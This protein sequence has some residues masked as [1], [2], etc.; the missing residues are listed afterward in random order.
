MIESIR[1]VDE[2]ANDVDIA[3]SSTICV[4][5]YKV[6]DGLNFRTVR[7]GVNASGPSDC[8][9][10]ESLVQRV[11]AAGEVRER[12]TNLNDVM[13]WL[14]LE[15][16]RARC[17]SLLVVLRIDGRCEGVSEPRESAGREETD[18]KWVRLFCTLRDS[19]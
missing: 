15:L 8:Y 2:E 18:S 17:E 3:E 7:A 11:S 14:L 10:L 9:R 6:N 19:H 5:F 13:I 1:N 12:R 16:L 4:G